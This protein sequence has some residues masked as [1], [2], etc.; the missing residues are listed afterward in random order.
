MAIYRR[1]AGSPRL[2]VA[3]SMALAAC[4]DPATVGTSAT[5]SDNSPTT[6][7]APAL[8]PL[9]TIPTAKGPHGID[10]AGGLVF[11]A[12][13][14]A[15][16]MEVV[17]PDG[18]GGT[19]AILRTLDFTALLPGT[20]AATVSASPSYTKADPGHNVVFALDGARKALRIVSPT[21]QDQ[22][23]YIQ[24]EG[25]PGSRLG[26]WNFRTALL[27]QSGVPANLF[28]VRWPEVAGV[29]DFAAVPATASFDLAPVA[30]GSAGGF[31]AVGKKYVAAPSGPDHAV[32]VSALKDDGSGLEGDKR[33]LQEGNE[34][35]P[36]EMGLVDGKDRLMYGNKTSNTIVVYDPTTGTLIGKP[37]T[38]STPTDSVLS[39]D[40]T[41][42]FV[43]CK[44]ADRVAVVDLVSGQILQH[45]LVGRKLDDK[46]A[47]PVH[48]YR[49]PSPV[50]GGP[51][52]I[53]VGGDG[54]ASVTVIDA[55]TY[56]VMHVIQV[57]NGHHKMA[58]TDRRAFVSN[59][60]DNT[61]SVI[62]RTQVK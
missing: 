5:A 54:D 45:V 33:I 35:G 34:P 41:K 43:T 7:G 39:A 17:D 19:G 13:P 4:A 15:G 28:W 58:F 62:D 48:V 6:S 2:L 24:M 10:V 51:D 55:T 8:T 26:W 56:K 47:S 27:Q 25:K 44:G 29:A 52:Q 37:T 22:V 50:P 11:N 1:A 40:K 18:N 59:I 12:N 20:A 9:A 3:L 21:T 31:I 61:L 32:V 30:T 38:L 14:S 60:V 46:P 16:K 23:G 53:W 57:G 36:I 49:V 42:A